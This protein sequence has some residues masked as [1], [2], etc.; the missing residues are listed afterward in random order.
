MSRSQRARHYQRRHGGIKPPRE[1]QSPSRSPSREPEEPVEQTEQV[2]I[3]LEAKETI[4]RKHHEATIAASEQAMIQIYEMMAHIESLTSRLAEELPVYLGILR[5]QRSGEP[6]TYEEY[7]RTDWQNLAHDDS[8]RWKYVVCSTEEARKIHETTSP[9]V[10][11]VELPALSP[12]VQRRSMSLYGPDGYL[13]YLSTKPD[14]D[15]HRYNVEVDTENYEHLRP[16]STRTFEAIPEFCNPDTGIINFLNL[17][18]WKPN[19]IPSSILGLRQYSFLR[20]QWEI[21]QSGKREEL[22]VNDLSACVAFQICGKAGVFSLPHIDHHGV[23]TTA[24]VEEGEKLWLSWPRLQDEEMIDWGR[25]KTTLGPAPAPFAIYL[26][27]GAI[28]HQ[29]AGTP[30]APFSITNILMTGTMFWD[31]RAMART[32]KLCLIERRFPEITN[33]DTAKELT[34]KLVRALQLEENEYYPWGPAEERNEYAEL[35][36]V[37]PARLP[38]MSSM[39]TNAGMD[40]TRAE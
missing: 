11:L 39:L 31:T 13:A 32:L 33:E 8:L 40:P 22:Q 27:K 35:L 14:I 4:I 19:E 36:K 12:H 20:D 21:N 15:V 17:A 28:L 38:K 37:Q 2:G 24:E 6:I 7:M 25:G 16:T 26:T 34:A 5:R 3:S 9:A 30:H 10:P 23:L 29:P 18:A 1:T